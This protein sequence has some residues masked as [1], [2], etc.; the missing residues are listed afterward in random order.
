MIR[1]RRLAVEGHAESDRPACGAAKYQVQVSRLE[2]ERNPASGAR[3]QRLFGLHIPPAIERP[4]VQGE[5]SG[6]RI[7]GLADPES[8]GIGERLGA[9]RTDIGLRTAD[10]GEVG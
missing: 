5:G 6:V 9:F 1:A 7:V 4:L 2:P 10:V 8:P 3:T